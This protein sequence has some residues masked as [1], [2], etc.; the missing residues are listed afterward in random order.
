MPKE[1]C[2]QM[3]PEVKGKIENVKEVKC[4]SKKSVDEEFPTDVNPEI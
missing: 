4:M 3:I 2:E 1:V